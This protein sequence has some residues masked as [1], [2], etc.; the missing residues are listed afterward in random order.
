MSGSDPLHPAKAALSDAII[1]LASA[2]EHTSK[3]S[4]KKSSGWNSLEIF[5]LLISA[6]TPLLVLYLGISI[7]RNQKSLDLVADQRVRSYDSI[8]DDLNRIHCFVTDVGTWKEETPTTI[9]SYKRVVD[10]VMYEDRGFWSPKTFQAF[11]D[12][13]NAAFVPYQG[14]GRDAQIRTEEWQKRNLSSWKADWHEHLT[15]EVD[16]NYQAAYT[17]LYNAFSDDLSLRQK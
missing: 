14:S 17:K 3:N 5:K 8:K 4:D 7:T 6:A 16:P 11:I 9:I 10:R 2:I 15:G 12:Y 13:E 1:K